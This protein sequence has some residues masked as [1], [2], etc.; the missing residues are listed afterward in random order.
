MTS[1]T[2]PGKLSR[3]PSDK[4]ASLSSRGVSVASLD[5]CEFE[6]SI[7]VRFEEQATAHR[8][9]LAVWDR[10]CAWSYE[11]LNAAANRLAR[12]LLARL[13]DANLPVA[14]LLE[15]GAPAIAAMLGVLKAGK[16]CVPL[17]PRFPVA[18]LKDMVVDSGSGLLVTGGPNTPCASDLAP[19]GLAVVDF[20]GQSSGA[21]A[22][23][24]RVRVAP[25]AIAF[26]HYT[27]GSTG[28][29]KG[30]PHSHRNWLHNVAVYTRA[31]GL[32]PDDRLT[33]LHS[34]AFSSGTVDFLMALL[35]GASSH[36]YDLRAEGM[37]GLA[38]H[39]SRHG[40]TALN[41]GPTPF[42]HFVRAM[43][44]GVRL[45][46][47]RLLVMGSEPL[48]W[49]DVELFRHRLTNSCRIVN[50]L[51]STET[52]NYRFLIVDAAMPIGRGR[53]PGGYPV[54]DQ[55]VLLLDEAGVE[56][57][58]GLV[59]EIAV[60][61]RY[62]SPGYLGRP[63]LTEEVFRADT[64][65]SANRVYRT[66]DLG[67]LRPD[68]CLEIHGRRDH[69]FKVRGHRVE[70]L[71]VEAAVRRHGSVREAAVAVRDDWAGDARLVAYIVPEGRAP[72]VGDLRRF[73][74][75]TLPD[76]MI[77][78]AVVVLEA[79]PLTPT[80][81]LDRRALPEPGPLRRETGASP[82]P[83]LTHVEATLAGI[84]AEVLGLG[85]IG[86]RDRFDDLGGHSLKATQ[87]ISRARVAFGVDLNIREMFEARDIV[88][89]SRVV[90][91]VLDAD[92]NGRTAEPEIRPTD[93]RGPCPLSSAQE[94]LWFLD[95]LE[96]DSPVY[97][98]PKAI[99]LRGPLDVAALRRSLDAIVDRHEALRTT[100][101]E[102][103]G[104]PHCGSRGR[105]AEFPCR[106]PVCR[107]CART[108]TGRRARIDSAGGSSTNPA[109]RSTS[110]AT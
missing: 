24:L 44:P 101:T 18:L 97:N 62:L 98:I 31:L 86:I 42:R 26:I 80:G 104:V 83:P 103:D 107:S 68:G 84:W 22:D 61:S 69:Q 81:K 56:V 43:S 7:P 17:D 15:A 20:D 85:P 77:P 4:I 76:H 99:R 14:V 60:R 59:G 75:E 95:H 55:E 57:A 65:G 37:D 79:L 25:D 11:D 39:V 48:L 21:R 47:L 10:S 49:D 6:S 87:V 52:L 34:C 54:G 12:D 109:A 72:G 2:R 13:G 73:L 9:R 90:L 46:G 53:V 19:Q 108:A 92:V 38:E 102:D 100:F 74:A 71:E 70:G 28:R 8:D 32:G 33:L 82:E 30:I 106:L 45:T 96:P 105:G 93:G 88:E 110:A 27:S 23:D 66:G 35:N 5:P 64:D 89:Q 63:D 36:P 51:G 3:L 67:L 50:R 16:V 91:K 58:P 41:W 78:S 94:R 1:K 40:I 29:P